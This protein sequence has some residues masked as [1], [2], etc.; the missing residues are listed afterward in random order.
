MYPDHFSESS[1]IMLLDVNIDPY[2]GNIAWL[3]TLLDDILPETGETKCF[4][5][6]FYPKN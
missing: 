6:P 5:T 3:K 2:K 1:V 4:L